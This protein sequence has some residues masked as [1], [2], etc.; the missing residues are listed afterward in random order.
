MEEKKFVISDLGVKVFV[1]YQDN[2]VID[3]DNPVLKKK[4]SYS[5]EIYPRGR[6][7]D[8]SRLGSQ[9]SEDAKSWN[10]FR[11]SQLQNDMQKYYSPVA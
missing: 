8:L 6:V 11:T 9:N 3:Q 1:H 7:K 2:I 5:R 4:A 10:L